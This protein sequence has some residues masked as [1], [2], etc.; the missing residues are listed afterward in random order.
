MANVFDIH[1]G[2]QMMEVF[3]TKALSEDI[4][5][6][7][8]RCNM[9]SFNKSKLDLF[10]NKVAVNLNVFCSFVINRIC[11][12]ME[13]RLVVTKEKSCLGVRIRK[14][15]S[16]EDNHISSQ[17]VEANVRYPA[18][19]EDLDTIC[20]FFDFQDT[21]ESPIKTQKPMIDLRVSKQLAQSEYEKALR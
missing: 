8:L 13:S 6:L 5:Q 7:V 9:L 3:K 2:Q 14:S 20:C 17:Q 21:R 11:N 4:N 15:L 1:L 10:P 18:S 19:A 12:N 16:K